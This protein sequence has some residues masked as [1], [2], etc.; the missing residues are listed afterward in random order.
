MLPRLTRLV[1]LEKDCA[2]LRTLKLS[3]ERDNFLRIV[4]ELSW[5]CLGIASELFS[6]TKLVEPTCYSIDINA[7]INHLNL[8]NFLSNPLPLLF[9]YFL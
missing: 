7:H 5:N 6:T 9:S 2:S 3:I 4:L 8:L 1:S